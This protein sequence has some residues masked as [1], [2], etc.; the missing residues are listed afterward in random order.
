MA[1]IKQIGP[2]RK[3][4]G[5]I[6]GITYVVRNG[7]TFVRSNPIMPA[8][9]Y[10]TPAALKRQ[11]IFKMIQ[12]HLKY[13]LRTIKQ[14]FTPKG[15]GNASNRYYAVNGKALK[16]ALDTL[17]D[18]MAAGEIVTIDDVEEAIC[19]YAAA[20]PKAITIG[21]LAGYGEVYLEGEWPST[22]T[23]R[24]A[25]GASTIVVIVAENGTTTTFNPD[26]STVVVESGSSGSSSGSGSGSGSETPTV[27][28]PVISGTTPFAE[29]TSAT[30]SCATAGASIYYTVDG[31]TPT[32]AS[33][34][35][36]GAIALT[37]T[38]TVKAIAIKDGVSSSVTTKVFTK[39]E[40]GG[41]T[42]TE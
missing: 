16:A 7:K 36:S 9:A 32:S 24:A 41:E 12:M 17:A 13:H 20:N 5:T 31:S 11:A 4:T 8:K 19:A 23:L 14:T 18:V 22:I 3:T 30:I 6:D 28:A 10:T 2:G 37:D 39:G 29:S 33:T 15:N 26:G 38:T 34:A 21:R 40:G 35:Y 27:A 25:A 42:E 1:Q